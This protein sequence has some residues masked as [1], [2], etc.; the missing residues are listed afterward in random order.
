ME[1]LE[2]NQRLDAPLTRKPYGFKGKSALRS[3]ALEIPMSPVKGLSSSK[4]R[5]IAPAND[6]AHTNREAMT[7]SPRKQGER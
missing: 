6:S 4:I 3:V 1:R 7:I 2:N 5:K